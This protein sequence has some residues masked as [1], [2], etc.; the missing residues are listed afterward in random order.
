LSLSLGIS[1]AGLIFGSI[2]P[3]VPSLLA[4]LLSLYAS[5]SICVKL[6]L[7]DGTRLGFNEHFV[8]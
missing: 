7:S 1:F 8:F 2:K 5:G 3:E 6:A 4:I